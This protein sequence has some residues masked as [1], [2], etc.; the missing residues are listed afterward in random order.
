VTDG[1]TTDWTIRR[2]TAADV[3]AVVE[4]RALMFESMGVPGVDD[5]RWRLAAHDWLEQRLA[6]RHTCVALAAAP[7]GRVVASAMG[8]VRFEMPSPVS[9]NGVWGVVNTVATQPEAR[10]RGLARACVVEVLRWL[11]EETEAHVVELFAT[12]AG[13]GLYEELG[14]TRTAW[15][16]MRMRLDR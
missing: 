6:G 10:R 1:T 8:G 11:R 12:G 15:P 4:L 14:F 16:A 7:D 5:P 9:P 3:G 2:A 13:A